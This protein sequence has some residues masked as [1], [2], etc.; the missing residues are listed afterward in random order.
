MKIEITQTFEITAEDISNLMVAAL[1]GGINYWC[2]SAKV[3][4]QPI[5]DWKYASEVIGLTNGIIELTDA[6]DHNVKWNLSQK[7]FLKGVELEIIYGSH[8]SFEN[9]IDN[10]DADV[11]DRIIQ[12]ALFGK[13]VFG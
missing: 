3:T 12:F 9:L 2:S 8:G 4:Q 7:K 5:E 11:A 6:E 1:E 10:H 13:L